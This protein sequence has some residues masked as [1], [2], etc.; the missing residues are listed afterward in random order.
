MLQEENGRTVKLTL[1]YMAKKRRAVHVGDDNISQRH[2][3]DEPDEPDEQPSKRTNE[4]IN[5]HR[6]VYSFKLIYLI[7]RS[8]FLDDFPHNMLRYFTSIRILI[9]S[10]KDPFPAAN[11]RPLL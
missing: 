4:R 11:P 6:P 3:P 9:E 5:H 2:E 7:E 1:S 10:R 8:C